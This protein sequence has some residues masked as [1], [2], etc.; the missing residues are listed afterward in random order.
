MTPEWSL[1]IAGHI[2]YSEGGAFISEVNSVTCCNF[3]VAVQPEESER[4][5]RGGAG[6]TDGA[7]EL[8][9][10]CAAGSYHYIGD[11]LCGWETKGFYN[12]PPCNK[13]TEQRN[14]AVA[15][16]EPYVCHGM[17]NICGCTLKFYTS[18]CHYKEHFLTFFFWLIL[19]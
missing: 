5:S 4:G 6:Q 14:T 10:V 9:Q 12:L 7:V 19:C 3:S 11:C 18:S 16:S 1:V 2:D 15:E 13:G 17:L 8:H